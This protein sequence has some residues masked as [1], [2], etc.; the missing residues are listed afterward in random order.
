M[1]EVASVIYGVTPDRRGGAELY[2]V[3]YADG[4]STLV[5]TGRRVNVAVSGEIRT[6]AGG[7]YEL[8]HDVFHAGLVHEGATAV[9]LVKATPVSQAR[10]RV[11]GEP[12]V[13]EQRYVREACE[14]DA[15]RSV[16]D[17]VVEALMEMSG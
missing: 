6:V 9:T 4:A 14:R 8:D 3:R 7:H 1:G 13:G 10:P 5:P 16:V 15:R 17:K 11:V 12:G 2:D